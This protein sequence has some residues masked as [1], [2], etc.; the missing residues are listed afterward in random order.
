MGQ[1]RSLGI[2]FCM[3]KIKEPMMK[4]SI[5]SFFHWN[6]KRKV[7]DPVIISSLFFTPETKMSADSLYPT[8][9]NL[10][11]P[12]LLQSQ[13]TQGFCVVDFATLCDERRSRSKIFLLF[14]WI[15]EPC[16]RK[17]K[18]LERS[19]LLGISQTIL[20]V[21]WEEAQL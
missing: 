2:L 5:F 21:M 14:I 13:K 11:H 3:P 15:K 16:V 10:L 18:G 1:S 17:F 20:R 12:T 6:R 4:R 19:K 9:L 8:I 7:H